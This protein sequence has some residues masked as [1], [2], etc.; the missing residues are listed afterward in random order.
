MSTYPKI[1]SK[2]LISYLEQNGFFVNRNIFFFPSH[3]LNFPHDSV[4]LKKIEKIK[5]YHIESTNNEN[6]LTPMVCT[7]QLQAQE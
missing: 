5:I 2:Y 3:S 4:A 1:T 7:A 6:G